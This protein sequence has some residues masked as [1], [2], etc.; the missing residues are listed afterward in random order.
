MKIIIGCIGLLLAFATP[1]FSQEK[2]HQAPRA[3]EQRGG[4]RDVG[5]GHVPTH[6][7]PPARSAPNRSSGNRAQE[8]R[9][10]QANPQESRPQEN[11]QQENRQQESRPQEARP[12]ENR[13]QQDRRSY[14]D[15]PEHP[16]APHVHHDN[17]WVGHNSGRDDPH[18]HVD[19][20]WEHG[21]FPGGFGRGHEYHLGGGGRDRFWFNSWFFSVA[22]YDYDYVD[23]WDWNNDP[24]VVYEDPDHPGWYLAYNSRTGTYVHVMYLG[25]R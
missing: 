1:A 20:P 21:R 7:P 15:R 16:E 13:G 24:I 4:S 8:N 22:P 17:T 18:Y 9:A 25:P 14:R 23:D 2:E 3:Q 19:H 5:G 10:P 6:G 11:R 12:Q